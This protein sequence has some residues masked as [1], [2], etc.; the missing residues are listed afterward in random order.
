MK[1]NPVCG[2]KPLQRKGQAL[3][4][5]PTPAKAKGSARP[6]LLA[7]GERIHLVLAGHKLES[8]NVV[9]RMHPGQKH[10]EARRAQ[11]DLLSALSDTAPGYSMMTTCAK[12]TLLTAY[13]TL[14][15]YL[16]IGTAKRGL[17]RGRSS[18][19]RARS[20]RRLR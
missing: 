18:A 9:M 3:R 20:G 1:S 16:T 14:D 12:S 4:R 5:L 7:P 15:S 17:S 2:K 11:R 8:W 10:K 13:G 19:K 6:L